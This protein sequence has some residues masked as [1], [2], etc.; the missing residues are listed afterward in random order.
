[1]NVLMDEHDEPTPHFLAIVEGMTRGAITGHKTVP[2]VGDF[3]VPAICNTDGNVSYWG[4]LDFT[5]TPEEDLFIEIERRFLA[6][7]QL[8]GQENIAG[9]GIVTLGAVI[10][11]APF[12][13]PQ[14]S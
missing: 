10:H 8:L 5:L 7:T 4:I 14:R 9:F 1:M 3:Y 11:R 6:A 2:G 12:A 13:P